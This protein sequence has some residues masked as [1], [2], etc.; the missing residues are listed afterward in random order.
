MKDRSGE[1]IAV[2]STFLIL[3][4]IFTCLR[5][6]VRA[7]F[8]KLGLDDVLAVLSLVSIVCNA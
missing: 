7:K 6:F 4:Y 3:G 1:L 2:L 8:T 5:C